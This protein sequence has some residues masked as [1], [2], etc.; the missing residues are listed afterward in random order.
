MRHYQHCTASPH[1]G[2][3][4]L[5]EAA[6]AIAL[7]ALPLHAHAAAAVAHWTLTDL[8]TLGGPFSTGYAINA[9]GQVTGGSS[10]QALDPITGYSG[11][12][13]FV[14]RGG[15][16]RDLGTLGGRT[17]VGFGI[18]AT[19]QVT[20][21]ADTGA[22]A[23]HAFLYSAGVMTDLGTLGGSSSQGSA[24]NATGQV[25]GTSNTSGDTSQ[26]AFLYR[27]GQMT[28]LGTLGGNSSFAWGI[29]NAGQVT[30][31]S[32]TAGS[33]SEHA[34][35]YASGGMKDLGTLGGTQSRGYA[36]NDAGHVTGDATLLGG[37]SHA[38]LYTGGALLDLGTLGGT[39]SAGY[40]VNG[41][42][43]VTGFAL[44]AGNTAVHAFV[45]NR[46]L[47]TD[48]NTVNGIAGSGWTLEVGQAINDFGQ[49]T[50]YGTDPSGRPN[51][52]F[53][54][55]LDRTVWESTIGGSWDGKNGWSAGVAPNA[56][57]PAAIDPL[58]SITITGPQGVGNVKQL[59]IGGDANVNNGIATLSLNGG[60]II[61][62]G[63]AGAFTT[64]TA[65]G[66]LTGSGTLTGAVVNLGTVNAVNLVLSGGLLNQGLVTGN[67]RLQTDLN[68]AAGS[69]LRIDAGQR[70]LLTGSAHRNSGSFDIHGGALE[71]TGEL[72]N[73][74]SGRLLLNG[75]QLTVNSGLVN[76]GQVLVTFGG[77]TVFG[78]VTNSIGGQI[79]LTGRSATTFQDAV[80]LQSGSELRVSAGSSVVFFGRMQQRTGAVLSGTGTK[81]YEGGFS[82]GGSPGLG[83][84]GG[85]V[86][87]G[88]ANLYVAEIG[89]VT[90]CTAACADDDAL[91]NSS[92]DKYI[93]AGPL[94]L[95]GTLKLVSWNGFTA[96]AGQ[97]FN[98]FDWGSTSG[99]FDAID[100]TGFALAADT[101]LDTS[102][103]YV[104]GTVGVLAAAVPEPAGRALM[105]GGI[106]LLAAVVRRRSG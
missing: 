80:D 51:R 16:M 48:L 38:F 60:T 24:I 58:R 98:L 89:G 100:A 31:Y 5:L 26:R 62:A 12:H 74:A 105:L 90:A 35:V 78:N 6:T 97:R 91:R 42:G 103:L 84:D 32:P 20:G 13:A 65:K 8:G 92:F 25:A 82:V 19:G 73:N 64:I 86:G 69:T 96:Q 11:V 72:T 101:V 76:S 23:S 94:V 47:M 7:C 66:V 56:N 95:G 77:N 63:A 70:L 30:G 104:D 81:L 44:T 45:A 88:A 17:S 43:V 39:H 41:D 1:G 79:I 15:A 75:G 59:T 27:N 106:G 71:V 14:S 22:N 49:L 61:V 4:G 102:R 52:A 2:L 29:N 99:S 28:D 87:F 36:I 50:G 3:P 85:G 67:G 68:N 37:A 55:T 54:L 9:N 18:N 21:A 46:G 33:T 53:L 83:I 40:G 57:T 34:F 93:V 10:T